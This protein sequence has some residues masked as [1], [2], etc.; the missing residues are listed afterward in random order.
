M[1]Q[2]RD[3]SGDNDAHGRNCALCWE[4]IQ[5]TAQHGMVMGTLRTPPG[6]R[7]RCPE[8]PNTRL[9]DQSSS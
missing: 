9:Q 6:G 2:I 7:F 4:S 1:E 8:D 5:R 3:D